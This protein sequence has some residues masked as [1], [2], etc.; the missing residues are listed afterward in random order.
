MANRSV[1]A[2]HRASSALPP[3]IAIGYHG[4]YR[5]IG[6]RQA[7][8]SSDT[9]SCSDYFMTEHNHEQL[10][11]APLRAAGALVSTFVH[12]FRTPC[13][14]LERWL[15]RRL[16]P[17]AY[18]ISDTVVLAP[19]I[20]DSAIRVLQ[21]ILSHYEHGSRAGHAGALLVRFDAIYQRPVTALPIDW[22]AVNLAFRAERHE[23][24]E[25][26]AT[27]DLFF[28]LP[29]R[30]GLALISALAFSASRTEVGDMHFAY[31]E[32]VH[33]VGAERISF[34]EPSN[35]GRSNIEA[36]HFAGHFLGLCRSCAW[37]ASDPGG[38]G[39]QQRCG[40]WTQRAA[41]THKGYAEQMAR[42]PEGWALSRLDRR[43]CTS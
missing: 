6:V 11:A 4:H 26:R 2:R 43:P 7:S 1:I 40:N 15:L 17:V 21:L 35:Y 22:A 39:L 32:L 34:L 37:I 20:A 41:W 31:D 24:R 42:H 36:P 27:S 18:E 30:L 23:W 25:S 8:S 19:R 10:V 14:W 16:Q 33:H 29:V 28:A 13:G 9:W 3:R 38:W 12:S 5:R